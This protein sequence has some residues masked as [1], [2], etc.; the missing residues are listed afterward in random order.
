MLGH[1][2]AV[3][4]FDKGY[5]DIVNLPSALNSYHRFFTDIAQDARRPALFH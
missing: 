1:G 4:L 2:N 5:R 3:K